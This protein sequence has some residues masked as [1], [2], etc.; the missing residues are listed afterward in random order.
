MHG[1]LVFLDSDPG[2]KS[3]SLQPYLY[4][5]MGT[6]TRLYHEGDNPFEHESLRPYDGKAVCVSGEP[7]HND[8]LIIRSI[9]LCSA[10]PDA[11]VST[12]DESEDFQ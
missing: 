1:I 11:D 9:A 3:A 12:P 5:G 2:T 10:L 4:T 7:N 6:L 8:I